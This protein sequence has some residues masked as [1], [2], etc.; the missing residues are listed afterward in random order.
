MPSH[1]KGAEGARYPGFPRS[2]GAKLLINDQML[3]PSRA[4]S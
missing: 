3:Y 1:R 2:T 4:S